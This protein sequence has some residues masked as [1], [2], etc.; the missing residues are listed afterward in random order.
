[1]LIA[2]TQRLKLRTINADDA[3]FYLQL[4]NDP[5]Y[6][7]NI[8]DKNI[9]TVEAAKISILTGPLA[10]Q[11]KNG[12]SLYLVIR[13]DDDKA[14]GI[15]GLIKRDTLKNVD[16]GYAFLPEFGGQGYAMEAA[17]A[18]VVYAYEHLGLEKLVA[19]TSPYNRNSNNLLAKLGFTLE[20]VVIL[21]G[22]SKETNLYSCSLP[23][24]I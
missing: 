5:S 20:D 18:V 11:E 12:F 17:K 2:M 4:L 15:C 6:I 14:I 9:R 3:G 1:M 8:N 22:E 19:I 7:K 23:P 13:K 24:E 16:I 10:S 21:E